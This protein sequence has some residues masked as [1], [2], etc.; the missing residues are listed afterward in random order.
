MKGLIKFLIGLV[1]FVLLLVFGFLFIISGS[2]NTPVSLYS[3]ENTSRDIL[4]EKLA[5]ELDSL[6]SDS[7]LD[8]NFT[9]DEINILIYNLIKKHLNPDYSPINADLESQKYIY[10]YKLDD[11][12]SLIGGKSIH[13]YGAYTILDG[14]EFI[15]EIPV[16]LLGIVDSKLSLDLSL[17]TNSSSYIF[18]INSL[19]LGRINLFRSIGSSILN[20]INLNDISDNSFFSIDLTNKQIIIDKGKLC[21]YL[22]SSSSSSDSENLTNDLLNI[23]FNPNYNILNI[24]VENSLFKAKA[25]LS[26]IAA[27]KNEISISEVITSDFDE[28]LFIANKTQSLLFNS[29]TSNSTTLTFSYNDINKLIYAKTNGYEGLSYDIPVTDSINFNIS[30]SG[31]ILKNVD[32]ILFINAILNL[33]NMYSIISIPCNTSNLSSKEVK[34]T[35]SE[36]FSIGDVVLSSDIIYPILTNTLK[37]LEFFTFADDK[38]IIINDSIFDSF[39][40]SNQIAS[41]FE[42]LG[43]NLSSTGLLV[44]IGITSSEVKEKVDTLTNGFKDL[45]STDFINSSNLEI[46]SDDEGES[47]EK[48][49]DTLSDIS[50]TLNSDN[51]LS[52]SQTDDIIE[53]INNLS[54]ENQKI[55]YDQI[56][57]NL[58]SENTDILESL[59]NDLFK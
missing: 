47:I 1:V 22:S 31:I 35:L 59:Y 58:D 19:K 40:E 45:L 29:I 30:L 56:K 28:D 52:I 5:T 23:L 32:G 11:S 14:D 46:S 10:T 26:A 50:D 48:L 3:E 55:L 36:K 15:V 44:E 2:N 25:D 37:D 53:C 12:I 6:S 57:N 54:S 17:S 20:L 51:N 41:N 34:I 4:N 7:S 18:K 38:S 42:I 27:D 13:I 39:I 49:M 43:L 8:F 9:E 33:N 24:N 21:S 16:D